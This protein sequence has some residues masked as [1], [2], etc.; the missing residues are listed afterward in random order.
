MATHL[1]E[2]YRE[3]FEALGDEYVLKAFFYLYSKEPNYTFEKEVL[4]KTLDIP[5]EKID[6]VIEKLNRFCFWHGGN[7]Y[8]INNEKRTLY[9]VRQRYEIVALLA[10]ANEFLFHAN[11]FSYQ[12]YRLNEPWL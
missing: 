4:A 8:E 2:K 5:D 9:T 1:N 6:N 11:S 12:S 3:L 10:I 7:E